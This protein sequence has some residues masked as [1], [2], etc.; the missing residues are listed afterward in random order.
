MSPPWNPGSWPLIV[1]RRTDP[2]APPLPPDDAKF[3]A[4]AV[5][6]GADYLVSG[7]DDL[8]T[9]AQ[10]EGVTILPPAKLLDVLET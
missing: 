3:V 8:L 7:D 4:C 2:N 5:S 1:N 10:V 6:A 9:L